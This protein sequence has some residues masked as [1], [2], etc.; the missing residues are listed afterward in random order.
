MTHATGVTCVPCGIW[1]GA[2][3][4]V[5]PKCGGFVIHG[6]HVPPVDCQCANCRPGRPA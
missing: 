4:Q 3:L 6:N 2:D 1:S 5:C